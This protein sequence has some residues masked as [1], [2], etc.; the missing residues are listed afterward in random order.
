MEHENGIRK[1]Q[2][3]TITV[4]PQHQQVITTVTVHPNE[5]PPVSTDPGVTYVQLNP[6]YFTTFS[7]ILKLIEIL[8]AVICMSC[9]S[10]AWKPGTSWFL[11]VVVICFIL[12]LFW[13]FAHLLSLVN[14]L[15]IGASW[16]SIE[17]GYNVVASILYFTAFI[18]QLAVWA[19]A[20]SYFTNSNV[21]A[22]VFALFNFVVY[23]FATFLLHREVKNQPK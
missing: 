9:A 16:L 3:A 1:Q 8:F 12:T 22:G 2:P 11:F 7:G 6:G 5:P 4:Y 17:Y 10:P 20:S 15:K 23:A 14:S 13:I 18:V 19:P 21:A